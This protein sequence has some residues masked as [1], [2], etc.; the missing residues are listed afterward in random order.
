[1]NK[2]LKI[3]I[4][5]VLISFASACSYKPMFLKKSY[6]FKIEQ[7]NLTGDKDI[8]SIIN[9]KLKFIKSNNIN[10]KK[11]YSVYLD[12]KKEKEE[13]QIF[14]EKTEEQPLILTKEIEE[15]NL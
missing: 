2:F 5:F 6:D 11:Y 1:M 9:R 13:P 10:Y 12:T 3:I 4:F 14:D 8:N 7:I 15:K